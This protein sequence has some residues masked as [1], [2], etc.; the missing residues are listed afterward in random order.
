MIITAGYFGLEEF[1][2]LDWEKEARSFTLSAVAPPFLVRGL[3]EKEL[4]G[5]GAKVLLVGSES[6]V[7]FVLVFLILILFG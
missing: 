1:D 3:V 4:L 5:K 6:G 7:S 2:S